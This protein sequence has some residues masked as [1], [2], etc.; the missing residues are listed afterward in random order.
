MSL[1]VMQF[2]EDGEDGLSKRNFLLILSGLFAV[3]AF[4]K[5]QDLFGILFLLLMVVIYE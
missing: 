3:L 2:S 4:W 5:G 1:R